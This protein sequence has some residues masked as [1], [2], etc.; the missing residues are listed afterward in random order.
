MVS[1]YFRARNQGLSRISGVKRHG[2]IK[3]VGSMLKY[4]Q[5]NKSVS[6]ANC[7]LLSV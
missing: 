3:R 4:P 7:V 1:A 2:G 5:K 6:F